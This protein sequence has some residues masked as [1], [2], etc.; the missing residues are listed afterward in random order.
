M[1]VTALERHLTPQELADLWNLHP[2]KIRRMFE[3]ESG[4]LRIGEPS[5]RVGR[6]LKR[7][8]HTMRIPQSVA[9]RVYK[10]L[11]A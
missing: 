4:V 1:S 10:K 8:Y 2:S 5:R 3:N 7:S 9:E 6:T 11:A